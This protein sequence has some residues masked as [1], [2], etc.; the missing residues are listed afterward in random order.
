[1][2]LLLALPAISR[3]PCPSRIADLEAVVKNLSL[4]KAALVIYLNPMNPLLPSF[5]LAVFPLTSGS[6]DGVFVTQLYAACEY[7]LSQVGGHL[8]CTGSDRDS[9]SF[10]AM[11]AR[12]RALGRDWAHVHPIPRKLSTHPSPHRHSSYYCYNF[13]Y[14]IFPP[15]LLL[16]LS[17]LPLHYLSKRNLIGASLPLPEHLFR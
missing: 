3:V 12:D 16:P 1:M 17:V 8:L 5:V 9:G 2:I 4:A 6:L 15:L 11:N 14:D 10:K 7:L 13:D